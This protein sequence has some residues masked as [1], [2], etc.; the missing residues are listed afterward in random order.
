MGF[1]EDQGQDVSGMVL[2]AGVRRL[3]AG[4]PVLPGDTQHVLQ[5]APGI[6]LEAG[7]R[8]SPAGD[9]V[10]PGDTQHVSQA[11]ASGSSGTVGLPPAFAGVLLPAVP[12]EGPTVAQLATV[13]A[14]FASIAP[15]STISV[16]AAAAR[17]T[18][19]AVRS[20]DIG[21]SFVSLTAGPGGGRSAASDEPAT[22]AHTSRPS[23]QDD[24]AP[25]INWDNR[26]DV[27]GNLASGPAAG[28]PAWLDDF[29]N[30]LGRSEAQRNP[31]AGMR[32]RPAPVTAAHV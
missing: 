4:D 9:P 3:P 24:A 31:N 27:A 12:P 13:T 18:S 7:V 23:E 8:R 30:H 17:A 11:A 29:L 15:V 5:A 2:E 26:I 32:V 6:V 21:G 16:P 22:P 28:S 20:D 19:S 1:A 14:A 10:L 25:T